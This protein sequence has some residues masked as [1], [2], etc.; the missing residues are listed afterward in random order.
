MPHAGPM[1]TDPALPVRGRLAVAAA[2]TFAAGV[3]HAAAAVPHFGDDT[4]LGAAF[5]VTGWVQIVVA[6]LLLRRRPA[7]GTVWASV[8][9]HFGALGA[10]VAARTVGLPIGHGGVEPIT[11]PDT[12]TAVLEVVALVVLAGWLRQPNRL[13]MPRPVVL[14]TL[15]L[16]GLLAMGGSTVAVAAL[17]TSGHG[18][19]EAPVAADAHDQAGHAHDDGT[20]DRDEH[21]RGSTDPGASGERVHVHDDDSVHVHAAGQGHEHDDGS[22]HVHLASQEPSPVQTAPES[23]THAPGEGHG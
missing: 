22:V 8:V 10:L 5:A 2:L 6:A 7:R 13:A 1:S 21:V 14:A 19:A 4:L 23:H 20:T 15:G 11:L 3:V 17:G 16:A 9:T 18:H 12:T